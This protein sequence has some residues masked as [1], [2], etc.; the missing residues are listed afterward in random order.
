MSEINLTNLKY[1]N[2]WNFWDEFA[3]LRGISRREHETNISLRNRF[4]SVNDYDSTV[5][6]LV[7]SLSHFFDT[8]KYNVLGKSVYY[9]IWGALSYEDYMRLIDKSEPYFSPE[10]IADGIVYKMPTGL[11][12]ASTPSN[13]FEKSFVEIDNCGRII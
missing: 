1:K 5:Q 9:S 3:L 8:R 10:V 11:A 13:N 12:D 4:L 2:M 6:G 7:N